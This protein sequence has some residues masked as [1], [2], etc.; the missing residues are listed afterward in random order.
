MDG[1]TEATGLGVFYGTKEFLSSGAFLAR[2]GLRAGIEGKSVV[3]QGFG[4]VG[5]YSAK[6]FAEGGARVVRV[7]VAPPLSPPSSVVPRYLRDIPSILKIRTPGIRTLSTPAPAAGS[8][9]P[10]PRRVAASAPAAIASRG[11]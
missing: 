10:R 9:P 6:F 7:P 4:N 11:A 2:H 5:Y 8:P 3:V 1:R